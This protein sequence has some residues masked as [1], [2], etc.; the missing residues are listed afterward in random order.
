MRLIGAGLF[1]FSGLLALVG[2][3]E[4]Q[5]V[6]DRAPSWLA[7]AGISACMLVLSAVALWLFNP[8]GSDPFGRK[9]AEEHLRELEQR[10]LLESAEFRA[11]RA[12]GVEEFEDEGLHYFVE[13]TDGRVLFLSGQY[14]YDYEPITD[15]PALNQPRKFP[16]SEF[17]VRRHKTEGYVVEIV[18]GGTVLEPESI[19]PPFGRRDWRENRIPEDGQVI[20]E[21]T[22][23]ELKRMRLG[24]AG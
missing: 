8:R 2:I 23:D 6:F 20:S 3:L 5:N 17:T 14:L 19:A 24:S 21:T 22:Y 1:V 18:C 12:F 13:L 7:G 4:S 9:S 16:C 11:A 10:G 15:D